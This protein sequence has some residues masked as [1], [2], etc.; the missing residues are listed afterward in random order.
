M[1]VVQ[2]YAIYYAPAP[3]SFADI[4]ARWLGWDAEI[5]QAALHPAIEG[6]PQPVA[7]LTATPR[8]YGFHG[9]IKPPFHLAP[10]TDVA[11]LHA[12][13]AVL[14]AR[15]A[16]VT[17]PG[18]QLAD[19]HGF[20]ALTPL[21]DTTMLAALAA[22]VVM[23]LDGFRAPP[24]V[25]EIARRKPDRLSERQRALLAQ[26]GYPYVLDQFQFHLTLTGSLTKADSA[27]TLRALEPHL[28]SLL[29]KPFVLA[30][31]VLFGQG[32][33]GM[34]RTLHRYPLLG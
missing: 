16:P 15:L 29:P 32:D 5:G 34:F 26:W 10:G 9:T 18:L 14:A 7:A 19:L 11:G 1:D 23:T 27:A 3:G 31:L 28:A 6:L 21:G 2:R 13:I 24:T 30:D 4:T 17:L 20:V 25:Q 22:D 12:A 33:D 8:K